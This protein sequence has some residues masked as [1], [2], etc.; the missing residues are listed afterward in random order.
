MSLNSPGR[1]IITAG[2]GIDP[3]MDEEVLLF[4]NRYREDELLSGVFSDQRAD[5]DGNPGGCYMA[6]LVDG[7]MEFTYIRSTGDLKE[8]KSVYPGVTITS[9]PYKNR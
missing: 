1:Y 5:E 4:G 3:Y 6:K 7:H 9:T 8:K 2:R